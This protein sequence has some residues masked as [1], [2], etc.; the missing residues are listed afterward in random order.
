MNGAQALITT[1]AACGVEVCFADPGTTEI[2]SVAALD[3]VDGMRGVLTLF[4]GDGPLGLRGGIDL[5]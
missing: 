1:L 5:D 4:E 2:Y 3:A